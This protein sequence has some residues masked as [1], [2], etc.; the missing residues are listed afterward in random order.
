MW[1]CINIGHSS[2]GWSIFRDLAHSTAEWVSLNPCTNHYRQA[3]SLFHPYALTRK[4][5]YSSESLKP[6]WYGDC[7]RHPCL[8]RREAS[9]INS[10]APKSW[11]VYRR[12]NAHPRYNAA[13]KSITMTT[14]T[15]PGD[16]R[17][18]PAVNTRFGGFPGVS[19]VF[20]RFIDDDHHRNKPS[21][22]F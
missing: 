21:F 5:P 8:T 6:S 12:T 14:W 16:S 7:T 15:K 22:V 10:P 20:D 19:N 9:N 4:L 18:D 2:L 1:S 17:A 11:V 13:L 3:P